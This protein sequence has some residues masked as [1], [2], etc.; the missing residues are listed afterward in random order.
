MKKSVDTN[1]FKLRE[2]LR[3]QEKIFGLSDMSNPEKA[4]FAF[5]AQGDSTISKIQ[6]N[7]YFKDY[8]LST[9]KRAII[10]LSTRGMIISK[11]SEYDKRE[12]ILS[13]S[14]L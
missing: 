2:E 8:S 9:I 6:R 1:L 3:S 10:N 7:D 13:C 5:I 11:I 12:R 4:I 14:S